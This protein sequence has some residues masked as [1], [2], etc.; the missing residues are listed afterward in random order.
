MKIT[1][2][3]LTPDM[4]RDMMRKNTH[5]RPIKRN[6]LA[7]LIRE[8]VEGRW[9]MNG[10][11]IRIGKD[12]SLID[13]QHRLVAIIQTGISINTV[14]MTGMDL[15]V[16]ETID[17]G[18]SR[19]HG[20][21]LAVAGQS[22]SRNLSAALIVV[23]ELLAGK[24]DFKRTKKI[25]NAEIL[26]LME[27]HVAIKNSLHW[28]RPTR[29]IV[30]YSVS[31]ALHYLFSQTS[32][33]KADSFFEKIRDGIGLKYDDPAYLLRQRLISNAT[34]KGKITRRYMIALFI[35]A[36]NA[37]SSSRSLKC[38]KF[39]DSGE[40]IETFPIIKGRQ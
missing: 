35:K 13:G 24:T 32:P 29:N 26:V 6:H 4:A 9:K 8:M 14:L 25:S 18:A 10:D 28:A 21:T 23:D 27:K 30:P 33:E 39:T 34:T 1:Q 22:N 16:F 20:D 11:P 19:S 31:V 3:V 7:F 38:L 5:N 15:D 2:V 37:Y 17:S 12:G 36:W 40:S